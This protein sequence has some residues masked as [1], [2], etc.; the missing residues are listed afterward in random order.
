VLANRLWQYHFGR[1][2]VPT[3]NDFGKL[4]EP[5]THPELL[6]W[7]ASELVSGGWRLKPIH[8][9]IV[10]SSAYRMSSRATPAELAAD[11][12]DRWFWRFPMRRLTAE[13]VRDA[14]LA[15][16]GELRLTAGGPSIRPPIPREVLAGQSMPG[17][18]W[19]VSPPDEAARRSV[20]IHVKRSLLVPILAT[21]DAADTDASCP[22]R[23]TTTVPTQAL[24]LLNGEFA[25]EQATR[26]ADR[27]RR[28]APGDLAAQVRRA[29][30]LTTAR[31]PGPDEVRRD[32]DFIRAL[33]GRSG[34]D[35]RAALT[36]YA[37]LVLNAN[38]FLYLD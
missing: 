11:P 27:L 19:D 29:L 7:L 22:V 13:E 14:I 31:E 33:R 9:L 16:S 34:L 25:N 15:V 3:P 26:L 37:L 20:Y 8:R 17:K 10:L 2:I 32:V 5:A 35:D 12:S 4:G 6:D 21:H 38:A 36:Q 18:G 1:G 24:G 28:E 30:R 23:Y